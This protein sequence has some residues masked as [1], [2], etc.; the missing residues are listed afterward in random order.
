[1]QTVRQDKGIIIVTDKSQRQ[2]RMTMGQHVEIE[3]EGPDAETAL[4]ALS[5]LVSGR[6]DEER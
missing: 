1:M 2:E 3:A 4:A 6:F 5:A